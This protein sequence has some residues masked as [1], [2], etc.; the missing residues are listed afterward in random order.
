[1]RSQGGYG[2][3]VRTLAVCEI[4]A[5]DP[6]RMVQQA[7]SWALRELAVHNAAAVSAFV[8]AY[9]ADLSSRTK[10]EVRHKLATG[11]KN[12]RQTANVET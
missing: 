1:M 7:I 8:E 3:T 11:L 5:R 2:D 4:L 12:P 10:R 6:E 9:E